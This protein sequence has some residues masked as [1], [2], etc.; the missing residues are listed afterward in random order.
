VVVEVKA[1]V[2]AGDIVDLAEWCPGCHRRVSEPSPHA[3]PHDD[4]LLSLER[5]T[6]RWFHML[7]RIVR[8]Q[9]GGATVSR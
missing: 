1:A 8:R 7:C 5:E 4:E 6:G 3:R 9:E 2:V